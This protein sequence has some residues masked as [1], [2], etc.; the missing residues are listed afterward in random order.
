MMDDLLLSGIEGNLL[1]MRL[2]LGESPV[3][4]GPPP[5]RARDS[6]M[7]DE[8]SASSNLSEG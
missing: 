2:G 4:V 8:M 7:L 3:V 1:E 6:E 5:S